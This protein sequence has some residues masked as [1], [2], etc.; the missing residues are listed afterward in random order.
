MIFYELSTVQWQATLDYVLVLTEAEKPSVIYPLHKIWQ[1]QIFEK[2]KKMQQIKSEREKSN[3]I[4]IRKT[5][6]QFDFLQL[7]YETIAYRIVDPGQ[8]PTPNCPLN[9]HTN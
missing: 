1:T 3:Q 6:G 8:I 2:L 7:P 5:Y 4:K 9:P